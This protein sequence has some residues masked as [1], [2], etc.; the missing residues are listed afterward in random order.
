ML[1]VQAVRLRS[2]H[3]LDFA[4]MPISSAQIYTG[5]ASL[6]RAFSLPDT[7]LVHRFDGFFEGLGGP[8][9]GGPLLGVVDGQVP[10]TVLNSIESSNDRGSH[11]F[12]NFHK[13]VVVR[14]EEHTSELQS[15]R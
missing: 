13:G 8:F 9:F 2:V 6:A 3:F 14:S 4:K 12:L 1:G 11:V 5:F 7:M 15:Q 10:S